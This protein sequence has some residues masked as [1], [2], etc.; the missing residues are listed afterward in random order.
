M[1]QFYTHY[2]GSI[3]WN[4]EDGRCEIEIYFSMH[5]YAKITAF[6]Y[7]MNGVTTVKENWPVA[8]SYITF[9]MFT[10]FSG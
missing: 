4:S 9:Y 8:V 7:K 2:L 3:P 1:L 6:C 5:F 10:N